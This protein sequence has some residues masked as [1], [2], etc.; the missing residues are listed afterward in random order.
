MQGIF[1]VER[2]GGGPSHRSGFD[3]PLVFLRCQEIQMCG[4][5]QCEPGVVSCRTLLIAIPPAPILHGAVKGVC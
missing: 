2:H 5:G 4:T 3:S 1:P